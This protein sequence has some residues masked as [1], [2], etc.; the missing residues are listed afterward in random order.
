MTALAALIFDFDGTIAETERDGHRVAYNRAFEDAR[1]SWR[2]DV[3]T[4][5]ALLTTA[6]GKER[7]DRFIRSER[8]GIDDG[9]CAEL[10]A[11]LHEAKR[12]HFD[13]LAD[14]LSLRPGIARLIAQARAEG[15]RCAIA[16]TAAPSGVDAVLRRHPALARAFECIAAGDIVPKKKPA[17][18]IYTYVVHNLGLAPGACLAFEDSAVGLRAA[19][20]AGIATLVTPS[21]YNVHECF[22]GAAAVVDGLGEPGGVVTTL[23]GP[24]PPRGYVDVAYL[25]DVHALRRAGS[26]LPPR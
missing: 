7:L 1:A 9:E 2:W 8:P 4:Y 25:R 18:D 20:A 16:T 11:L 12:R 17:P 6:G 10:V 3:A 21:A 26:S 14:A 24:P 15:L 13:A 23:A 19:N 22:A 5:G